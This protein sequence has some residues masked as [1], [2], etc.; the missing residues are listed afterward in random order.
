MERL[1][2]SY[3]DG[4]VVYQY[5]IR[6]VPVWSNSTDKIIRPDWRY[7]QDCAAVSRLAIGGAVRET[8]SDLIQLRVHPLYA[9][10][11]HVERNVEVT[12]LASDVEVAQVLEE[13]R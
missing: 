8:G 5:E 6:D 4:S 9:R 13:L 3:D 12:P 11:R 2:F 1:A 7:V 10:V